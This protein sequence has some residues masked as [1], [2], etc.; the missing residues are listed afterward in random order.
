M[1]CVLR[2]GPLYDVSMR[3]PRFEGAAHRFLS[4]NVAGFRAL[5]KKVRGCV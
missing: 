2:A 3:P 5:I 1:W 4:W